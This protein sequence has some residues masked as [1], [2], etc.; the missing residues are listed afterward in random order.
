MS[1]LEHLLQQCTVKLTLPG[2]FGWGTGFFVAPGWILTCAHVVKEAKGEPIKVRWQ[3]QENW[4]QAVVERSLAD[5]Y[6]LA[7]LRVTLPIDAKPPCVYLDEEFSAGHTLYACGYSDE[8]PEGA[9]LLGECEGDA[10]ENNSRLILFK[11]TRVRSGMSGSPLLNLQTKAIC[12]IVKFTRDR[13]FDLGGGAIPAH[14]I[15]EQFPQLRDLQREFHEGDR[16][17]GELVTEP[18]GIDFQPYLKA[19]ATTYKKWWEYYTFTDAEGKQRQSKDASPIFDFGLMVQTVKKEEREQQQEEKI[20]RFSVLEGIRKYADQHVLLIGR[21]GS[22]K[23]T[24]LA[25]LLLEEADPQKSE[26][27]QKSEVLKTSDFSPARNPARIPVLVELRYWQGSI[28]RLILNAFAR[29]GL[30]LTVE[31]LETVLSRSLILFDGVNELP[32]EEARSQLSAFRRDHPKL[33]MIFT[34]RDLSLGGDL[35]IEQKLEMRPLT[36][37]QMQAFIRAYVPEQAEVMLRQLKDRLREFGQ[38]PLLL[39]MLCEVFQQTPD[40]Q[41]PSNLAGVFQTFTTTYEN[42]SV[43]KYEVA[44]LKGDVRPLSDRRLWKQALKALASIMMQGE[45]PVD[46]RVVI[47]RDD[48]ERELSRVFPTEQFPVRDILDDLLKYHLLQNRTTDQI[49]FRHQLIQDYYA[50]EYLLQLLP[51][52]TDEQLKRDY[53]NYLKWTEAIAL[54]LALVEKES[55]A[56]RVVRLALD[57]DLMLGAR[58]AGEVRSDFQEFHLE[59]VLKQESSLTLTLLLLAESGSHK[60]IPALKNALK[61]ENSEIRELIVLALGKTKSEQA[62]DVL[63]IVKDDVEVVRGAVPRALEEIGNPSAIS[64]LREWKRNEKSPYVAIRIETALWHLCGDEE[65]P[66]LFCTISI[67]DWEESSYLEE[68]YGEINL[69]TLSKAIQHYNPRVRELAI[70][71][72]SKMP[73]RKATKLLIA[74]LKQ[75][76]DT[77]KRWDILIALEKRVLEPEHVRSL[78]SVLPDILTDPFPPI[79]ESVAK[80]MSHFADQKAL[81]ALSFALSDADSRVR[82]A[83]INSLSHINGEVAI[84]ILGAHLSGQRSEDHLDVIKALGETASDL[85]TPYLMQIL[86]KTNDPFLEITLIKALGKTAS[87]N[88][89]SDLISRRDNSADCE[90]VQVLAGTIQAIQN[91]CKFYNYGFREAVIQN[92]EQALLSG[93][94]P[95]PQTADLLAKID[96][97]TQQID[98]RT[99]QMADQPKYHFPN[100]QKV[101]I[102]ERVGT[103][104]ENNYLTDS[105][106]EAAIAD[107]Q[108]LLTQLQTQHPQVTTEPQALAIIDAEFTEIK[109]SNPHRLVTLRQQLLNPERHLQATK[110]AFGEFAKHY[111]EES[112]WAKMI[113]TYLDKLSEEP[114]HGA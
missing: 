21:P 114:N 44:A 95:Q 41:L 103:Y 46:F 111:L 69:S 26:V 79:R 52:L 108:T 49:E 27:S 25:R 89:L 5:P 78:A 106:T 73:E 107:L 20:E 47:H 39:W 70:D 10:T 60:A 100:A 85:A 16:R 40:Q 19:I 98:R 91:R 90:I 97:T 53:L 101:Q 11:A 113:I 45:T 92:E 7:L 72:L 58:L 43:R 9:S 63:Q 74:G 110:A 66:S 36:E 87:G 23:S 55:Q 81:P 1:Q 37:A 35:G 57:V 84:N 105:D 102:F 99:Q 83:A 30:L 50:A 94:T 31:Q 88:L 28:A 15:L 48:A 76:V 18:S 104:N 3:N 54:M 33:P 80:I 65:M 71:S 67:D 93:Q 14:V 34:T 24:A 4:A 86:V 75:A 13:S 64:I 109:R 17:W 32:S 12:G 8:F 96:Q 61:H 38:T 42:R 56:L 51:G 68:L 22:G 77:S 112:V 59:D 2:R 82:R 6:D 29:H 62:I